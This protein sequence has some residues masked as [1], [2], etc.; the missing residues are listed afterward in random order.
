MLSFL[1]Y[2]TMFFFLKIWYAA[3]IDISCKFQ[4]PRKT[5]IDVSEQ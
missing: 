2:K 4:N 3:R 1:R 5:R